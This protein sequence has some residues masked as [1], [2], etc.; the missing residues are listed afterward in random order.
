MAP[1]PPD[2]PP[3]AAVQR[4]RGLGAAVPLQARTPPQGPAPLPVAALT[5]APAPR[6]VPM[7]APP[8]LAGAAGPVRVQRDM[9][10]S[11]ARQT[12]T[13]AFE[14]L[15][16][17]EPPATAPARSGPPSGDGPPPGPAEEEP[18][19]Y[20]E[21]ADG[22]FDPRDLTDFQLD[23]LVRRLFDPLSQLLRTD[24]RHERERI[25][26]LRDPRR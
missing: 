11:V 18:P 12:P 1:S 23:S 13:A 26:R 17:Y 22:G 16:A 14:A 25:G 2:A 15:P 19:A 6:P 20:S 3:V 4:R 21:I 8:R 24:L 10:P 9:A 7:P 5:P